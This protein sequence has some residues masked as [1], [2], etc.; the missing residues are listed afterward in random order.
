MGHIDHKVGTMSELVDISMEALPA[1]LYP[2]LFSL[3]N[4]MDSDQNRYLPPTLRLS[5]ESIEP[6]GIYLL[7]IA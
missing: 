5:Q 1:L 2:R 3:H 7:G 6:R 4:L